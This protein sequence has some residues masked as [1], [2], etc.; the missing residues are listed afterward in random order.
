MK[1]V[2]AE[3]PGPVRAGE[4]EHHVAARPGL[5][6]GSDFKQTRLEGS[7]HQPVRTDKHLPLVRTLHGLALTCRGTADLA[8]VC[9]VDGAQRAVAARQRLQ[10]TA[11]PT[12]RTECFQIP[13]RRQVANHCDA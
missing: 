12:T 13:M 5:C 1:Q 6:S 3:S 10:T 9:E 7:S 4:G 2:A 11:L 8:S